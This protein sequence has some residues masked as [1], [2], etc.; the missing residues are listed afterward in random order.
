MKRLSILFALALLTQAQGTAQQN[1]DIEVS[2]NSGYVLPTSP[3]AFSNYWKMQYGGGIGVGLPL[4]ESVTLLGSAEYYQF[5]LKPEGVSDGF[6]TQYMR[7]IWAFTSVSLAPT[8]GKSSVMSAS[9]N[10]RFTPSTQ[11]AV[12]SPYFLS[13]VGAMKLSLSEISLPT[14][15]VITVNGNAISMTALQTITGGDQT[16]VLVQFGVGLDVHVA[17][18]VLVFGEARFVH[19]FSKGLGTSYMPL[20]AGLKFRL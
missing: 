2:A 19:G 15:S 18:N 3:M 12:L 17:D 13:G 11:T 7:D 4:S 5:E 1:Y 6:H 16:S 14:Q 20:T 8:A 10:I 9:A